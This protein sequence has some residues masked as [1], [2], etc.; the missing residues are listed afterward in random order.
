MKAAGELLPVTAQMERLR[1]YATE[2]GSGETDLAEA[3]IDILSRDPEERP[4]AQAPRAIRAVKGKVGVIPIYGPVDQRMTSELEKA[5]GTPLDFVSAALDS[6]LANTSVGAIVLRFDSPGG[7]VQGVQELGDRIYA[8]RA[9]KP[10]FAIAD[11]LAASAALWLA[12]AASMFISTPGANSVTVG[13][14]GVYTMHVDKS[15]ALENEGVKITM[16][17]AGKFKGEGAPHQ[18]L[19]AETVAY[20][21]ERVDSIMAQF[22]ASLAKFRDKAPGYVRDNFGQGRMLTAQQALDVGVIDR[23]LTFTELIAKLTGGA[24]QATSGPSAAKLLALH[25]YEEEEAI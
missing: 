18:P 19:S 16:V 5:G 22:T 8:A 11:S 15:K 6:L 3:A 23:V 7:S 4:L 14:H 21:Q 13:S 2:A 1:V 12:S 17:S 10:I 25:E 24:T 20:L 9:E